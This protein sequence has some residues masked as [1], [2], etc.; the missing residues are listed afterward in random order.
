VLDAGW[1]G[2]VAGRL[3]AAHDLFRDGRRRHVDF[4]D[5]Q[6]QQHIAHRATHH[7]RL[8]AVAIEQRQ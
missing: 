1:H 8:L 2:L 4:L 7:A 6:P 3:D 5:R